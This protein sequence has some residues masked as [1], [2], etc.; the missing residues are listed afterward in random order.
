MPLGA[1]EALAAL[2]LEDPNLRSA[3]LVQH[4]GHDACACDEWRSCRHL[5]SIPTEQQDL[6][7]RYFGADADADV[8]QRHHVAGGYLHLPST[9]LDDRVHG[10]TPV[11]PR[12][13]PVALRRSR[14]KR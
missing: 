14:A 7:S 12:C 9:T 1:A 3:H 8:I 11:W 13:R 5:A 10:G 4:G 6:I 2:F